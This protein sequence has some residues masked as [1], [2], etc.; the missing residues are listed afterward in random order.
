M[1]KSFKGLSK[2]NASHIASRRDRSIIFKQTLLDAAISNEFGFKE[3]DILPL[4]VKYQ[5]KRQILID[6][7]SFLTYVVQLP[8]QFYLR[9]LRNSNFIPKNN[10][11]SDASSSQEYLDWHLRSPKGFPRS[12]SK[13]KPS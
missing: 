9:R 1:F 3:Q 10:R 4:F 12:Q 2:Y 8:T 7:F 5:S 13:T 11:D 6:I